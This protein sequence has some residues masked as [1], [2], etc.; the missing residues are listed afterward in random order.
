MDELSELLKP[1][2]GS[3]QWILEG[4]NQIT[5]EEKIV[6]K[7][8][9]DKLFKNG[10]PFELKHEKILYIYIFSMLAQLEV[11]AIQVPLKF[12]SRM[13]SREHQK[14]MRAQLLDEIFHGLVFTKIL[15]LLC[16][17]Q[18]F[19]PEYNDG[20]E[21]LCNFIREEECPKVAVVLLNLVAEGWIEETF[22]LLKKADI[23]PEVFDIIIEDEHRHVCEAD[24]Y[25]EIGL[26]DIKIIMPKL[27]FLET[28]LINNV[29]LQYKYM[30]STSVILGMNGAL[31]FL[32][33]LDEKHRR[34]LAKINLH[35]SDNWDF[36]MKFTRELLPRLQIFQTSHPIAMT[37]IR[38]MFMTQWDNPSDPTM[39]GEF[40]MDVSRL[41]FFN[42][43]YPPE[44]ITTLMLQVISKGLTENESW[45]SY[46]SHGQL[47]KSEQA[48]VGLVVKLVNCQDH[49]STIV[50][51]NCHLMTCQQLATKIRRIIRMMIYCFKK[52]E[53]LEKSYPFL[54]NIMDKELYD[55]KNG[56]YPYPTPGN[57]VVSLSNIGFCGYTRAKSPLRRNE[58]MK[59]TLLQIERKPVWNEESN[60][61]VP[62]DMLPVSISADH[63]IIDGNTVVPQLFAKYFDEMFNKMIADQLISVQNINRPDDKF[64]KLMEEL[65]RD[66][67]EFAYK[68]L[69]FLQTY[70]VD[71]LALENLAHSKTAKKLLTKYMLGRAIPVC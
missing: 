23:A 52:R 11:L 65:M 54:K 36:F 43:K 35:P 53:E 45:R 63:R 2:W 50:F 70:W 16:A 14:L 22:H 56:F 6:I 1:S 32:N 7:E 49:L 60:S 30:A 29:L 5:S 19:P 37:P 61:F 4:W 44:T 33:C 13:S 59:C 67:L 62:K 34:Q 31:D 71:A 17:P 38:K 66:N 41:D 55:F 58:A 21:S 51:D 24:L 18:A 8:R 46:L 42:K 10:L 69:V 25:K 3:E 20:I 47:F 64:V 48:S 12:E 26:P 57:A 27:Q 28:Q 39:V 9:M 40:S 15:Y 68:A